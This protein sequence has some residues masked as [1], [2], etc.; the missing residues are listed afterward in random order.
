MAIQTEGLLNRFYS[1]ETRSIRREIVELALHKSMTTYFLM[2]SI[3]MENIFGFFS[4]KSK[5][6]RPPS[7]HLKYKLGFRKGKSIPEQSYLE[8]YGP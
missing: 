7:G 3:S 6:R 4:F 5:G 1:Q 8:E 2:N